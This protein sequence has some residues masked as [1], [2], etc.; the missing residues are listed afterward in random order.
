MMDQVLMRNIAERINA[1]ANFTDGDMIEE[2]QNVF[3]DVGDYIDEYTQKFGY[4]VKETNEHK[5]V[6]FSNDWNG[7][8]EALLR[9]MDHYRYI[10]CDTVDR[11]DPYEYKYHCPSGIGLV[12]KNEPT[13]Y[14]Y[15]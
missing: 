11:D 10:H 12:Y 14:P 15:R 8:Y 1:Y 13:H 9:I 3:D 2:A 4:F 5:Q 7:M 6:T